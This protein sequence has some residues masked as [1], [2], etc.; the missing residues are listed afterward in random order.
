[1]PPRNSLPEDVEVQRDGDRLAVPE[2]AD[3]GTG[4]LLDGS[5]SS[6]QAGWACGGEGLVGD[7]VLGGRLGDSRSGLVVRAF[8]GGLSLLLLWEDLAEHCEDRDLCSTSGISR[9]EPIDEAS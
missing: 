6:R 9:L 8:L 3:R 1:M 2:D 5:G 4:E 7:G